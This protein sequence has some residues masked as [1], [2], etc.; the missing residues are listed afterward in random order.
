MTQHYNIKTKTTQ[1]IKST[2]NQSLASKQEQSKHNLNT[3]NQD[4]KRT[5]E[6]KS[7]MNRMVPSRERELTGGLM[8]VI[9]ATPSAPTSKTV[10]PILRILF[11]FMLKIEAFSNC[12][13]F[14]EPGFV[15]RRCF[16][17]TRKSV[18]LSSEE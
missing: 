4:L 2:K 1:V 17:Y 10:L 8:M 11:V 14:W 3:T 16:F 5:D 6:L 9:S 12:L 13:G 18:V 15:I 7:S